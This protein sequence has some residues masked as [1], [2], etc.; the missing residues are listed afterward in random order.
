M[1]ASCGRRRRRLVRGLALAVLLVTASPSLA[2]VRIHAS[3]RGAGDETSHVTIWID[4]DR[5][6]VEGR[7]PKAPPARRRIVFR[8]DEDALFFLDQE[9]R[10]FYRLDPETAAETASQVGG[11]RDGLAAGLDVLSPAQRARVQELLGGLAPTAR[12]APPEVEL[13]DADAA[14][15]Y[16][17]L[18]CRRFDVISDGA[19][20]ADLCVAS[21]GQGPLR[22]DALAAVPALIAFLNKTVPSLLEAFP[23]LT[24]LSSVVALREVDG[25]PLQGRSY[26]GGKARTETVVRNLRELAVE[27]SLFQ[28]PDGY[29]RSWIPPFQ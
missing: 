5:L 14:G 6:A 13:R 29:A 8:A 4:G 10:T 21:Y 3:T 16:A 18:A 27:P 20:V 9:K 15:S 24:D 23:E 7:R 17:D 26:D 11:V 19:R 12:P 2:G 25:L 1:V 22:R 28:V